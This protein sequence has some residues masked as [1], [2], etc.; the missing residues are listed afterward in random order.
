MTNES[1]NGN[2]IIVCA[3]ILF[4]RKSTYGECNDLDDLLIVGPR[5][6]DQVMRNQVSK[7]GYS[8]ENKTQRIKE[9][10]QGFIDQYGK[11]YNRKDALEIAKSNNQIRFNLDYDTDELFSE[12][13][14]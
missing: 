3:A 11:F 4:S 5:H 14:Y 8:S 9:K 2:P 1:R 7:Y 6:Y 10:E 13:L 12:M